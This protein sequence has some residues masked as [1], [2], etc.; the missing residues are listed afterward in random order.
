MRYIVWI[1]GTVMLCGCGV[2]HQQKISQTSEFRLFIRDFFNNESYQKAHIQF[3]LQVIYYTYNADQMP[4]QT[5]KWIR[6]QEW[7]YYPGP[8]YYQCA[9]NCFDIVI[10]DSFRKYHHPSNERV[11]SFEGVDNGINSSLYFKRINGQWYLVKDEQL[12]D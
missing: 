4:V 6:K 1:A 8:A 10:Y 2:F 5:S 9:M 12:D 7:Q 3:P 11:L